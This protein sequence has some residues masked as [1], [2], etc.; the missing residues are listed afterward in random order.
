MVVVQAFIPSTQ[1]AEAGRFLNS[2][3]AWSIE[4]VPGQPGLRRETL[5]QKT[6]NKINKKFIIIRSNKQS[7]SSKLI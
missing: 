7:I 2:K 5:S 6:D 1:E 4:Q 3:P